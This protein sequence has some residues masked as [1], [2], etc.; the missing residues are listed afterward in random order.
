MKFVHLKDQFGDFTAF[1][2]IKGLK[3]IVTNRDRGVFFSGV[4]QRVTHRP[5]PART[6][7]WIRCRAFTRIRFGL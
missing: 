7:K 2:L 5:I 4:V 3:I 6:A 1:S